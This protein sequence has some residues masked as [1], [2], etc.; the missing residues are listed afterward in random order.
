MKKFDLTILTISVLVLALV[1]LGVTTSGGGHSAAT[2]ATVNGEK[3]TEQQL[4]DAMK[5]KYGDKT[6]SALTS[7]I[8]IE[9][10]AKKTGTVVDE[11][12]VQDELK[13]LKA[14]LGSEDAYK[15]YLERRSYTEESLTTKLKE[16][17]LVQKLTAAYNK[18]HN[19]KLTPNDY[20]DELNKNAQIVISDP[21]LQKK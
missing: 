4:Y 17:L 6:L 10:E 15:T 11:K 20:V 19:S 18:Q 16:L 12:Q 5:Q 3:V 2:V 7:S 1:I 21:L 8:L 13:Q 9:Q 14:K